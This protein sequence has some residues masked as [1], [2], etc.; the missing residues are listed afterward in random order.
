VSVSVSVSWSASVSV[1]VPV[2]VCILDICCASRIMNVPEELTEEEAMVWG[3][4]WR[5]WGGDVF[6]QPG[7]RVLSRSLSISLSPGRRGR[8]GERIEK[9]AGVGKATH[10]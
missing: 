5:G 10:E 8:G 6:A 1:P 2:S 9:R 3:G 7:L 4:G